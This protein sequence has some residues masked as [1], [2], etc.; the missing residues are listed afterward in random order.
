MCFFQTQSKHIYTCLQGYKLQI[1]VEHLNLWYLLLSSPLWSIFPFLKIISG[2]EIHPINSRAFFGPWPPG[3]IWWN[4]RTLSK[5]VRL[6]KTSPG[7]QSLDKM[8]TTYSTVNWTPNKL[9]QS[10]RKLLVACCEDVEFL[11]CLCVTP[12][13]KSVWTLLIWM[14]F[15]AG[16][17]NTTVVIHFKAAP[18]FTKFQSLQSNSI[19]NWG[20]QLKTKTE[21]FQKQNFW[22]P[23]FMTLNSNSRLSRTKTTA[24]ITFTHKTFNHVIGFNFCSYW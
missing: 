14:N 16:N 22:H 19:P 11:E 10:S 23:K 6:F 17:M 3:A 12:Q 1:N 4:P 15:T 2:F 24:T 8:K 9:Y 5:F 7:W 21:I 20:V 13:P 18:F